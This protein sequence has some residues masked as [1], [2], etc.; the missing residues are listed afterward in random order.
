MRPLRRHLNPGNAVLTGLLETSVWGIVAYTLVVTHLTIICVTVYL[1]RHQAHRALELH[2][3]VSHPMRFWLWLTTGM[4]TRQWVAVHRKHHAWVESEQDPHS[5]RQEGIFK[6]LLEGTEL[7]RK[8]TARKGTLER[9]GHGAPDDWIERKLYTRW[10]SKGY[11]LM[12][13]V[14]LLLFGPIGLTVWAVQMLWI[15]F[16]AAG[17]INGTGHWWGYRN[18]ETADMSTNV[19]PFGLI[20]GGEEL[21]NNHHAFAS[22]AKLSVKW[23]EFDAGW[24]YIRVLQALGLARVKKLPPKTVLVPGKLLD[25]DAVAAI[26]A[27]RFSVMSSYAKTVLSQ[28][29]AEELRRVDT[30]KRSLL[31]PAKSLMVREESMM[32]RE[33]VERLQGILE[34]SQ[35]LATVYRYKQRLQAIWQERSMSH[36]GLLRALE[37]WCHEA[38]ESGIRALRD[39]ARTLPAYSLARV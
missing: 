35:A 30:S 5:P 22:S 10:T 13:A 19:I 11:C 31:L 18:F 27:G 16:F 15:P 23:W 34:H 1:H 36:D 24:L 3:L 12:L 28:V 17:V 8:E 32:S 37:D 38:E 2:P 6:V 25:R 20:I 4:V 29:W 14:N 26:I 9:Y 21:H 39:F 7:Y 33:A